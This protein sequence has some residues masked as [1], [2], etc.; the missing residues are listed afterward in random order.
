[1][2]K[3]TVFK[4]EDLSAMAAETFGSRSRIASSVTPK[5]DALGSKQVRNDLKTLIQRAG[6]KINLL[7]GTVPNEGIQYAEELNLFCG[8]IE[9][10]VV[11]LR[12][13]I[14]A[15]SQKRRSG[16]SHNKL[17]RGVAKDICT[18]LASVHEEVQ[19]YVSERYSLPE[20]RGEGPQ[21]VLAT[22]NVADKREWIT[23]QL[24]YLFLNKGIDQYL[25]SLREGG[26]LSEDEV[27]EADDLKAMRAYLICVCKTY[28]ELERAVDQ[29]LA[30]DPDPGPA[31][32]YSWL[33]V[34]LKSI[35]ENNKA[36]MVG[37]LRKLGPG[38]E[39][40]REKTIVLADAFGEFIKG[41]VE[42][43][44]SSSPGFLEIS[45][46]GGQRMVDRFSEDSYVLPRKHDV[47]QKNKPHLVR[48]RGRHRGVSARESEKYFEEVV[49]CTSLRDLDTAE[50]RLL[51]SQV[52]RHRTTLAP[53]ES[54][55]RKQMVEIAEV[56]N[57][58]FHGGL[59]YRIGVELTE[60]VRQLDIET[61]SSKRALEL[62]NKRNG[63]YYADLLHENGRV[64]L[65]KVFQA[66]VMI[67]REDL[68]EGDVSGVEE[69][70]GAEIAIGKEDAEAIIEFMQGLQVKIEEYVENLT[71]T[72]GASE[73]SMRSAFVEHAGTAEREVR[74]LLDN[75][76]EGFHYFDS[77]TIEVEFDSAA[78][79]KEL[80][81][82]EGAFPS[83]RGEIKFWDLLWK[84]FLGVNYINSEAAVSN[85]EITELT[86]YC[87]AFVASEGFDSQAPVSEEKLVEWTNS[88]NEN[89]HAGCEHRSA[90]FVKPLV[91][92]IIKTE[93]ERRE[94]DDVPVRIGPELLR[95]KE[96]ISAWFKELSSYYLDRR[97]E[98]ERQDRA[99]GKV[100]TFK[101]LW[102]WKM[103][104]VLND[105]LDVAV[106]IGTSVEVEWR[107]TG[108]EGIKNL[109]SI[110]RTKLK[111]EV[112][113][114]RI[115]LY[116]KA[117]FEKLFK[118]PGEVGARYKAS[119]GLDSA[120]AQLDQELDVLR[121]ELE[122]KETKEIR[123]TSLRERHG[124]LVEVAQALAGEVVT[125]EEELEALQEE[126]S[127]KLMAVLSRREMIDLVAAAKKQAGFQNKMAV[128]E[129]KKAEARE[130][131]A[132]ADRM[133]AQIAALEAEVE[134]FGEIARELE[135]VQEEKDEL[136]RSSE[137]RS[138]AAKERS[139]ERREAR[140]KGKTSK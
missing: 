118:F 105:M 43:G 26:F 128:I 42:T 33:K 36:D 71:K 8:A 85:M 137:A 74:V 1:V 52:K 114:V 126:H 99:E 65:E 4:K 110:S 59:M 31:V 11:E 49:R 113:D 89:L 120:L 80:K 82:P 48:R 112:K 90:G 37:T 27:L 7:I 16:A 93:K 40:L 123:L 73:A 96:V 115:K 92:K 34:A 104:Q 54:L 51:V 129:V 132:E 68:V 117:D 46:S 116:S 66:L 20:M 83:W 29:G 70:K 107:V 39:A 111:G 124:V 47:S 13:A 79:A 9:S 88:L 50:K 102:Q 103:V 14:M 12:R 56:L 22:L 69:L 10:T 28:R 98:K 122:A 72:A 91:E 133:L 19:G 64:Y 18:A 58:R 130:E 45:Y 35:Y 61:Q 3:K 77:P 67:A 87:K 125:L 136:I 134:A 95:R 53:G 5:I 21:G 44:D 84:E 55:G 75:E 60:L 135:E 131:S 30:K 2:P 41:L 57:D 6:Q 121:E 76:T 23:L 17:K 32:T 109:T 139:R 15:V 62:E 97:Q 24:N 63:E 86:T 138:L 119:D 127:E 81:V 78:V 100:R 94:K 25:S 101:E 108:L 140:R 38:V 106:E